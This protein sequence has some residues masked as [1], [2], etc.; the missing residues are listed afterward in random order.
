MAHPLKPVISINGIA[1]KSVL[2]SSQSCLYL[3]DA[4]QFLKLTNKDKIFIII[5][6]MIVEESTEDCIAKDAEELLQSYSGFYYLLEFR[7]GS[8]RI[9]SSL[10][11]ILPIYYSDNNREILISSRADY[12]KNLSPNNFSLDKQYLLETVLFNHGLD[13]NTFWQGIHLLSANT[14]LAITGDGILLEKYFNVEDI[15]TSNPL[16]W[17]SSIN[18]LVEYFIHRSKYYFRDQKCM[19]SFTGGFDGRTLLACAINHGIEYETYSFGS[20]ANTDIT[21][22]LKISNKLDVP[23]TPIYLNTK[24]YYREFIKTGQELI[25]ICDG[26]N[27]FLHVHYLYSAKKLRDGVCLING[28]FGSELMRAP[29]VSGQVTSGPLVDLFLEDDPNIWMNKILKSDRLKYLKPSLF[30]SE[31]SQLKEKLST[32]K[33]GLKQT[34][35]TKNQKLYKF[36]FEETFRKVFGSFILPQLKYAKLRSPFLDI[37]FIKRLLQTQLA[38]VNNDFYTHN[39]LKRYKGQQ[40]YARIIQKTCKPLLY[41]YNDKGYKPDNLLNPWGLFRIILGYS[42]KRL[43]RKLVQQDYDNLGI[44]SAFEKNEKFF[45]SI[46]IQ[47]FFNKQK[48]SH[49]LNDTQWYYKILDRDNLIRSMSLAW[50]IN[51]EF[52]E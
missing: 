7:K 26:N 41:E 8:I 18:E 38:G 17:R 21:I 19:L 52:T 36:L 5:G 11:G 27:S 34:G 48:I 35:L 25:D 42:K 3:T 50:F 46:E 20:P 12:I 45:K 23:F 10:F 30:N 32:I 15:F 4:T 6:D 24:E 29:H 37:K 47:D 13:R 1:F 31:I 39:P 43:K 49:M 14:G 16:P 2:D 22:P 9:F 28:M 51:K 40:L 33:I 44:L